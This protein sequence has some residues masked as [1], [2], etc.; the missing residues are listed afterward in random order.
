LK[1]LLRT[2]LP[3]IPVLLLLQFASAQLPHLTPFSA[4]LEISSTGS[5]AGQ[6][7]MQGKLF[8]ATGHMRMNMDNPTGRQTAIITD[9]ATK[10]VDILLVPQQMYIEHKAGDMPGRGPGAGPTQDL[11]PY[12]PDHPCATQ[13]DLTCKKIGVE[14]VS[15]RTCDHWE[16]TDKGG[17][18]TNLW[19]DQKLHFPIKTVS[20]NSTLLLSNIKEGEPDAALFTVPADF[21]K[22]D[23]R[24]MMPPS[25]G[26]PPHQ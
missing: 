13:P 22:V 14:D 6:R 12:D 2:L 15:G 24:G 25:G 20:Q 11:K 10:T 1:A 3:A 23:M 4:D 9:F 17:K 21:H 18:V 5:D 7:D 8:V 16:I 26:G 19:I